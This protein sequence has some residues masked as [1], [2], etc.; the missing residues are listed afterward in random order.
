VFNLIDWTTLGNATTNGFD[1][2]TDFDFSDAA[3][4]FGLTWE[5]DRFLS[6]GI[7]YVIPEPS[8]S[9]LLLTGLI[10]ALSRRRR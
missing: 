9:L 2:E 7:I 6:D 1:P 8:R 5:T 3:L 10:V 4:D